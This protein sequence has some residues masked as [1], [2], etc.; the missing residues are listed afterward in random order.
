MRILLVEDDPALIDI[1]S[2]GLAEQNYAIDVVTDGERGWDYGSTYSYD[3]IILDWSLP[4]L[5]GISLCRRFR[6]RGDDTPILLLT[7]RNGIQDKIEGLDAGADDYICKPVELEELMARIRALLRRINSNPSPLLTW[8]DLQLDPRSCEVRYKNKLITLTGKEYA[9]LELFLRHS[10][11]VLSIEEIINSLWSSVEYPSEATV[12]SHLRRLRNKL[13]QAGLLQ[14]PIETVQ[15]RG[16][17]LKHIKVNEDKSDNL[18]NESQQEKRN[19]HLAN[20]QGIWEKYRERGKQQLITLQETVQAAIEGTLDPDDRRTAV[21]TAHNLAGN[22]GMFG[23]DRASLLAKD[24]EKLLQQNESDT[25]Q[26]A[27]MWQTLLE[28]LHEELNAEEDN[29]AAID[30]CLDRE[31][32]LLLI[33]DDNIPES[34]Q[35]AITANNEGIE[36]IVFQSPESAS[37]WL[38]GRSNEQLPALALIKLS[39]SER[40]SP[41]RVAEYNLVEQIPETFSLIAELKLLVP[42]VPTIVIAERDRFQDRLQVVRHGGCVYLKQPLTPKQIIAS[43]QQL[44]QCSPSGKRIA[45]VDDDEELL[46]SFPSLLQPWGFKVTTL[47][48]PRQFWDFLPVVH[49]D[50]LILDIEMPHLSGIELCQ[51]L[52]SHPYWCKVPILCLSVR[53]DSNLRDRVFAS[54]ADDLIYKPIVPQQLASRIVNHLGRSRLNR[55]IV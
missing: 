32:P 9:L 5:D 45:I 34:T 48:D 52:R 40:D 51:V 11:E 47:H 41:A 3:L 13:K 24:L 17:A 20:L 29:T 44:L 54:G 15:G 28:A 36:T 4:K 25:S 2:I 26:Q 6:D 49:P 10:H 38:L 27:V 18:Q 16:Y 31:R 53:N 42:S 21:F 19:R 1:L 46:R 50:L 39:P 37:N 22:L 23:F 30:C 14:D 8:G 43:C 7:A 12:R 33:V 55:S 35:L